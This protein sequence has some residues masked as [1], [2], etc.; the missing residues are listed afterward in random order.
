MRVFV[1]DEDRQTAADIEAALGKSGYSVTVG[2]DRTAVLGYDV[3]FLGAGNDDGAEACREIRRTSD[4]PI[5]VLSARDD[6]TERVRGLR[7]GADDYLVKP[8]GM[9]E[10]EARM[11]AV[12]R[13]TR[14]GKT[15]VLQA[16]DIQID[17][18]RYLVW[19]DGRN[20]PLTPKEFALLRRL[21]Q[22]PGEVVTKQTLLL[23]NWK[24]LSRSAARTLDVHIAHLR[25]KLGEPNVVETVRGVGYRLVP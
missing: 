13:R 5:I 17:A 9:E 2:P 22:T 4:V 8:V 25:A 15:D 18:K 20:V 14:G 16:G 7:A 24:D 23:E 12:L 11:E 1:V 21:V 19:R 10:L 3:V 6:P